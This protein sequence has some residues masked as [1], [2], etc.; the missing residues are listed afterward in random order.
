MSLRNYVKTSLARQFGMLTIVIMLAFTLL[1]SVLIVYENQLQQSFERENEKF[2]RKMVLASDL[3]YSFN[4]AISEMRAYLAYGGLETYYTNVEKQREIVDER[5]SNLHDI[6][7][8]TEDELFVERTGD[9]YNYYFKDVLPRFK[10]FYDNGLYE[11]V[12]KIAVS[13]NASEQIRTYQSNVK[14][15]MDGLREQHSREQ[16]EQKNKFLLIQLIFVGVLLLLIGGMAV[17][18]RVT[19]WRIRMPLSRLTLAASEIAEGRPVMF[20]NLSNRQDELGV[21]SMAFE[22]MARSIQEKEDDLS[23]RNQELLAQQE[24]LQTQQIHLEQALKETRSRETDLMRR[25]G[26][27]KGLSNSLDKREVLHS[28]VK[29]M[30]EIVE[31]DKGI[32]VLLEKG[33]ESASFGVS[34]QGTQQ[35]LEHLDGGLV[36]RLQ[37]TKKPYVIKRESLFSEKGY[38]TNHSFTFDLFLPVLTASG[39]VAG[40]MMFSR[41]DKA[42]LDSEINEYVNL[43]KQ[44]AISLDKIKLFEQTEAERLL[45]QNIL[46]TI[47]EGIQLVDVS[48]RVIQVNQKLCDML[49]CQS[50]AI[51]DSEYEKWTMDFSEAVKNGPEL[52]EFF[53]QVLFSKGETPSFV[54]HQMSPFQ[55]FIQVYCESL[56][57]DGEKMGTVIVHRDITKEYEVD[58][59]KSELVSTVSHELRTPLASVLGFAELMLHKEFPAE[60]QRKYL[61]AIYQEAK[62]LTALVNDFLDVQKMEAGKQEYH[63]SNVDI[64]PMLSE[65]I[66]MYEVNHP[67]HV[68]RLSDDKV[69]TVVFGDWDK[70]AQVFN[71]LISNAVKYSPEGGSVDVRFFEEDNYLNVEIKDEGLGIPAEAVKD[72]FEKFYRVDNS[73]RRKIGGTGLGLA[74]VKE[75]M[76]EHEGEVFVESA[77][78]E[79]SIFTV[80]LPKV[81]A[82]SRI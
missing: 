6:A 32:I 22:K 18:I 10:E 76:K 9:F 56:T 28:I 8:T 51:V 58:A 24:Q 30:T 37:D 77:L 54:Y 25:N 21:L 78:N 20:P 14:D 7:E 67:T 59:M 1:I 11:E 49:E 15:Y 43:S 17:L 29:T 66:E 5:I 40:V 34:E 4:L 75:I 27:N 33:N 80:K 13:Q 12:T 70:L 63:K 50:G 71:N 64:L 44:I 72:I 41:Y 16:E 2:E 73:D 53:D 36:T 57:R 48:G 42:F 39:E 35:F 60:R 38:H 69:N 68:F 79:G 45:T 47:K 23:A 3:E 81:L 55:R 61:T 65:I 82:E 31:A 26:L 46:D 62:R 52:K 19:I 74:I